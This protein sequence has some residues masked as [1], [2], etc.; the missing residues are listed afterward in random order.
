M[1]NNPEKD[2]EA[3]RERELAVIT[4]I[5]DKLGFKLESSQPHIAGERYIMRAVTTTSGRK[6]IL[7]GRRIKDNVRVVIKATND[8]G[9]IHELEHERECR[10]VLQ[11]INFAYHVFL[12]PEEILFTKRAGYTLSVQSFIEQESTFLARPLKE[13]FALALKAFKAQEGAHATT[14]GHEHL[15][16]KTFGS[17]NATNY[18]DAFEKFKRNIFRELPDGMVSKSIL[19]EASKRL[20]EGQEVIE[21]YCGFL[22]HT[23]L[24][25]HNIRVKDGEIYLLDH[26]SLRFGNKYE[27]WMRFINFMTLYNP[28]LADALIEY[29]RLNRT[30]EELLSLRLMR[31]YRLGEI[32]WYYVNTLDKCTG[33]LHTLNTERVKFWARVLEAVL[34]DEP[35]PQDVLERYRTIRDTLRSPEEKVRQ[36]DLH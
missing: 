14:Y 6:L 29:V 33:D 23:D 28:P 26:S 9:G 25:P 7:L 18:L 27:G 20:T 5:L 8:P 1:Q 11:K 30:P 10:R 19:D 36:K 15:V 12:S 35:V 21:Q 32:I 24:I 31:I 16:R 2:W 4:P 34:R 13:Q 17:M 3:Y 22:T